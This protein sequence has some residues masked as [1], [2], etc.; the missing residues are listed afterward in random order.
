MKLSHIETKEL[1][2]SL[3]NAYPSGKV[4]K[5]LRR[6]HLRQS[7]KTRRTRVKLFVLTDVFVTTYGHAFMMP[8]G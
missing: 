5:T 8:D 4:F 7:V 1:I 3:R 6:I 2:L